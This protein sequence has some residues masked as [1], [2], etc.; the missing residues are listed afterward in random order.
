MAEKRKTRQKSMNP[1]IREKQVI[2]LAYDLAERQ[3]ME[4]TASS[5][6]ITHFLKLGTEKA[7]IEQEMLKNQSQ[8]ISAKALSIE[9]DRDSKDLAAEAI[10]AIK[11][12]APSQEL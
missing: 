5:A 11:N 1:D 10:E 9:H 3:L 7:K 6:V 12:Y 4:G 2:D 8:L